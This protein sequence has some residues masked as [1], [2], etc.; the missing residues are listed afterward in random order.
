MFQCE[1]CKH[2][3]HVVH[4]SGRVAE[5]E[6]C[7][8]CGAKWACTLIHNMST[9]TNKQMVKMQVRRRG[10]SP[11]VCVCVFLCVCVCVCACVCVRV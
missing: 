3:H 7:N 11:F 5:P 1:R 10:G 9:F 4:D 6:Q 8:G 2:A